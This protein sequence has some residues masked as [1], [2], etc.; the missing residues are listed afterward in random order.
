MMSQN[1]SQ[2]K[3]RLAAEIDH[4]VNIKAEIKTG[5]IISRLDDLERG[6]HALHAEQLSAMS[7]AR[8]E[9]RG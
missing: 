5:L 4:Q 8:Q 3:D 1:R 7:R 9:G 2:D 6:M